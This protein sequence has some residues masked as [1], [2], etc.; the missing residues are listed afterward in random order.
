VAEGPVE[1]MTALESEE[2]AGSEAPVAAEGEGGMMH[3]PK[4]SMPPGL[5]LE[6]P[7]V[8]KT[9]RKGKCCGRGVWARRSWGRR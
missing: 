7:A 1:V 2:E 5:T 8:F 4:D 9:P 3:M 6:P